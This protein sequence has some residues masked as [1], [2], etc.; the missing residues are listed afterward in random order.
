[1]TRWTESREVY[2]AFAVVVREEQVLLTTRR[3]EH[4]VFHGHAD[5]AL[6]LPRHVLVLVDDGVERPV[7]GRILQ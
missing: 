7:P 5:G 2:A 3:V 6:E 4:V 1:M